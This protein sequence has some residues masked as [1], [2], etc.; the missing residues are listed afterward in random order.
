[1]YRPRQKLFLPYRKYLL[2]AVVLFFLGIAVGVAAIIYY[3]D[4]VQST[5]DQLRA[6]LERLGQ[7]VFE[8]QLGAGIV[9]LFLHNLRALAVIIFLGLILGL[10]PIFA[11]LLNGFIIG[12]VGTVASHSMGI[13]G[14]LASILPH[15]IIEIPALLLG[16]GIGLRLGLAPLFNR[17]SS[18]FSTPTASSWRGYRQELAAAVRFF[19]LCGGMLLVAAVIEVAITPHIMFL[20]IKS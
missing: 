18:P 4:L 5:F 8:Q 12:I 11:M 20:F 19:F 1:M 13:L 2:A 3:P 17:K 15:G 6:E 9:I 16:A 10:Y 14:F 7:N